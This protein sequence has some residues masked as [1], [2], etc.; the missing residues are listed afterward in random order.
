MNWYEKLNQK[1]KLKKGHNSY[2]NLDRAVY[3]SLLMENKCCKF[4]NN[5]SSDFEKK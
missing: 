5:I 3:S 2:K 1:L 4:Q